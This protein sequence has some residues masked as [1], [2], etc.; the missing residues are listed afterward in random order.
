MRKDWKYIAYL[1][2]AVVI[3]LIMTMT[4]PREF[5]WTV[6]F[7]QED[8]NP[9]GGYALNEVITDVF[10]KS[11]LKRTNNTI[12][13]LLDSLKS[14]M[15]LISFSARFSAGK[16]DTEALLKNVERGGNAFIA[17]NYFHNVFADT[18]SLST[19]DYFFDDTYKSL[20]SKN[21]SAV[22][23]FKNP[24][25]PQKEFRYPRKNIHNY[26]DDF[27]STR[28]SIIAVND[29]NLPVLIRLTFGKGSI[30]LCSAPL[31]FTN[32]HLLTDNNH[33][34]VEQSLSYI[35]EG[36]VQWTS[37][38]H[39][40]RMEVT[41]PLRFVL[42]NPSLRWAYYIAIGCLALFIIFEAKRRQRIIP[43]V[44]PLEN[45]SLEFVTTVGNLYYQN[46]DHKNIADKKISFL[47]EQIRTKYLIG[48]NSPDETFI[49]T[50]AKKAGCPEENTRELFNTIARIQRQDRIT[51]NDLTDLNSKIE[52]FTNE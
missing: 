3:Y 9:F 34:F 36:S 41:T 11:D 38:Y 16:A 2:I 42:S 6:T 1:G 15:T 45:T 22:L 29:F 51:A 35:P 21:D 32:I 18:L 7:H 24:R 44:K 47:L 43:I 20:F 25:L 33:K 26:F 13:E 31:A 5:D 27:D 10:S 46:A 30:Y 19:S 50:L 28:T 23:K 17:A 52:K 48:T 37:Y 12:Y 39:L 8:K 4:G 40:G 14:P 49:R